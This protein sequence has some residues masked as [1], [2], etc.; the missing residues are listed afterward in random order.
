MRFIGRGMNY[1]IGDKL[2]DKFNK[3]NV[4]PIRV[5]P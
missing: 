1:K 3:R 4:P 5:V 2:R